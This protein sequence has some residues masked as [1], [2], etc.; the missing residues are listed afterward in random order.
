MKKSEGKVSRDAAAAAPKR[1]VRRSP[2][3]ESEIDNDIMRA[4]RALVE[5]RGF[6]ALT[7]TSVMKKARVEPQV[8]YKR[9]KDL[10]AL[11]HEFALRNDTITAPLDSAGRPMF[12]DEA[13]PLVN[14]SPQ[15]AAGFIDALYA[16]RYMQRMLAWALDSRHP[17]PRRSAFMREMKM[18]PHM[19]KL[20]KSFENTGVDIAALTALITGGI[21]YAIMHKDVAPFCGVDFKTEDGKRRLIDASALLM[22]EI[23]KKNSN[24]SVSRN[25][26]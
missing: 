9:Y 13:H 10:D 5:E 24:V 7:V 1:R 18:R 2:R 23:Y 8:F 14:G 22:K 20:I 17:I 4:T 21:Y 15:T 26:G 12:A 25:G 19:E 16:D 6:A 3:D 11:L